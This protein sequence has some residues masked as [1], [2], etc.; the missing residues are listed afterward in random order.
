MTN[1][2]NIH[3]HFAD[4]NTNICIKNSIETENFN[5][6]KEQNLFFSAGV[7]PWN[8]EKENLEKVLT[9]ISQLIEN[10]RIIAIGE[11]GLDK[12]CDSDFQLQKFFFEQQLHLAQSFNFPVIIHCVKAHSDIL[13][14]L[15]RLKITIP[16]IFH[17]FSGNLQI[18][19]SLNKYFSFFSFGKNLFFAKAKLLDFIKEI[20]LEKIF[21]ETDD[22]EIPIEDVYLQASKIL[23]ID[24]EILKMKT[25]ENFNRIFLQK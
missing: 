9:N 21:F 11:I 14:I 8:V 7:H 13:E 5:E 4:K 3:T 6:K 22:S 25:L 1:F 15:K 20:P 16:L 2:I 12:I 19:N 18:Y 23:Q 10:K 17:Q 24:V